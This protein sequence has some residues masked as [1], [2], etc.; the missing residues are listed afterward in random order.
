M[1]GALETCAWLGIHINLELFLF[2]FFEYSVKKKLL[3]K[4]R[5]GG[6][7]RY[8]PLSPPGVIGP[9]FANCDAALLL[10]IS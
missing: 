5:G 4:K 1:Y 3:G 7:E 10:L 2:L 9:V 8:S 6:G